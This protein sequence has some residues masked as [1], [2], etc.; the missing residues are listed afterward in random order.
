MAK[1]PKPNELMM[2]HGFPE[3][4]W[5]DTPAVFKPGNF[6]YPGKAKNLNALGLPNPREWS[7]LDEDW[8]L[9][10]DWKQIILEGLREMTRQVPLAQDF[11]GHMRAL[12]RLRR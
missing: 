2:N 9:P 10:S 4:G 11:H 7:P 3:T 8:K 1:V 6:S 5:M 12:R